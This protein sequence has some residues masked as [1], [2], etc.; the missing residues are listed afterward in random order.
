LRNAFI[1]GAKSA[2]M[3]RPTPILV[4]SGRRGFTH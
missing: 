1:L 2:N 3:V 4:S